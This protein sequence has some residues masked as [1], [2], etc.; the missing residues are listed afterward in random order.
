MTLSRIRVPLGFVVGAL[1][2]Y[3]AMP[4]PRFIV[5]GLPLAALGLLWRASAAGIIRK[6]HSLASDGPY[7]FTRNPL[8]FGSFLLALGFSLMSGSLVCALLVLIPFGLIYPR[9]IF[10]EESH[11]SKLFGREYETFKQTIPAF[12]PRRI[13]WSMFESFSFQQYRTNGEYNAGLGFVAV[14]AILLLKTLA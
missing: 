7:R 8:Y 4:T 6:D 11:L 5:A 1:V 14:L 10:R 3:L 13:G 9:V 2:L 12:F